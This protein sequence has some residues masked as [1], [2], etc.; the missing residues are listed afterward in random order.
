MNKKT[1][2]NC[3]NTLKIITLIG[4]MGSG[5]TKFGSF[6]SH[7]LRYEFYDIDSMIEKKFSKTISEIFKKKSENYFRNEEKKT[8]YNAVQTIK[9]KNINSIISLG[10]G[11]FDNLETQNLLLLN[12]FVI[13]L[14]CPMHTLVKRIGH[15]KNRPM[16]KTNIERSL[17]IL[18]NKRISYYKKAHLK[19]DTSNITFN[20]MT[21]QI[22]NNI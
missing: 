7:K 3:T 19:F 18:L 16:L 17:R 2:E 14:D 11:G 13:W 15:T 22:L 6:L 12:S 1:F 21:D 20:K 8:I 4:M 5:K 10:G 9:R